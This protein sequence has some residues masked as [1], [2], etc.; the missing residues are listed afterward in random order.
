MSIQIVNGFIGFIAISFTGVAIGQT[1]VPHTFQAGQPAR[2]AEVNANFD[3]LETAVDNNAAGI[4]SNSSIT[5]SNITEIQIN[6]TN[7]ATN[8]SAIAAHM[9]GNHYLSVPAEAFHSARYNSG[10]YNSFGGGGVTTGD[11]G[12]VIAPLN[13]PDGVVLDEFTLY[14][15]DS[16][17]VV[18]EDLSVG[19]EF[20]EHG[21]NVAFIRGQITTTGSP[22]DTSDS[23][24][25]YHVVNN[26]L[27]HYFIRAYFERSPANQTLRIKSAIIRYHVP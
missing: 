6:A 25:T 3:E 4:A 11:N 17:A 23:V 26:Q 12:V 19:L 10:Y 21:G 8:T 7:I 2:A 5:S 22:G 24:G 13:F 27:Y 20:R 18:G 16:T 14:F 9:A 1:Q 15:E